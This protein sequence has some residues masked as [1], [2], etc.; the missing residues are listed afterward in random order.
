MT[1]NSKTG[2]IGNENPKKNDFIGNGFILA[3]LFGIVLDA[4]KAGKRC[5]T[6][7]Y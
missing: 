2:G 1:S 6:E 4:G 3:D 7:S 5:Y